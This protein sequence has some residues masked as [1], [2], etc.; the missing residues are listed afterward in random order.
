[1]TAADPTARNPIESAGSKRGAIS[2]VLLRLVKSEYFVL[3]L[4][5]VYALAAYPFVPILF[6]AEVIGNILADM[7]PLLILAVGQTFVLVIAGIDLSVT[8]VI[9]LAA[10]MGASIMTTQGGYLPGAV[11]VV[12]ALILMIAAGAGVG[13]INGL[14]VTRLNMPPFLVTLATRMFFA[15]FAIWYTTFHTTSS[16]IAGLPAEFT[17]LADGF[18]LSFEAGGSTFTLPMAPVA[19]AV[20][21][22]V[23]AHLALS[24]SVLGRWLYAVGANRKAARISGVPVEKAIILAFVISALC[25]AVAGILLS[26][27]LQ[28]G[29]PILGENMLLDIIGAVVIGGTSLFGGKGKVLWTVF[30]V[31]FLVLLDT[32]LKLLGA[33][34]STIFIIKGAVI[35]LAAVLDT[36]RNR[37]FVES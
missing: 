12:P 15:G 30:G 29:S 18:L 19:I 1:M 27:R 36:L 11:G 37:V 4:C 24:H 22:V 16:S 13:L 2:S 31:L 33:P 17:S 8:A 9:A 25:G 26:A 21:V 7:M 6:S 5:I 28:T 23:A 10:V 32:T 35:L 34:L 20:A 3:L 14:S